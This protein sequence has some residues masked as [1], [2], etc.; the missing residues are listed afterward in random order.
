MELNIK[1]PLPYRRLNI[2]S[3]RSALA[4]TYQINGA[5][6]YPSSCSNSKLVACNK[7]TL[8]REWLRDL[9]VYFPNTKEFRQKSSRQGRTNM[10][11]LKCRKLGLR[12]TGKTLPKSNDPPTR[13]EL[14]KGIKVIK[15]KG[16]H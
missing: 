12:R 4:W 13:H 9:G 2:L 10:D 7:K 6:I 8:N 16:W 15:I 11:I 14:D 1:V 5:R 3:S